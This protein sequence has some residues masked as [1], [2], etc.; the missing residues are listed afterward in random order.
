[1]KKLFVVIGGSGSGKTTLVAELV[2][3]H[4]DKF[5]KIVT[6]TSRTMRAGE[7]DGKEYNF[8]PQ[9]FFV[10]NQR[11][12]LVKYSENGA[13]YGTREHNLYSETHHL[14]LTSKPTGVPKLIQLGFRNIIVLRINIDEKLKVERM[15]QRG[16]SED[17]ISCRLVLD[18][19]A[20][21]VDFSKVSVVEIGA[22]QSLDRKVELVLQVC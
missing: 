22:E 7:I 19:L 14:L 9:N 11:L 20:T 10:N 13:C 18:N 6:C 17:E 12:V 1:M 5:K 21:D 4:S 16:D 8:F 3:R 2:K 15:K